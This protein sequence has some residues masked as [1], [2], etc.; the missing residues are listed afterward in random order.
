MT[1]MSVVSGWAPVSTMLTK[2]AAV[3]WPGIVLLTVLVP[4][5]LSRPDS[6]FIHSFILVFIQ[7]FVYAFARWLAGL[8]VQSFVQYCMHS[9]I[10]P[11]L[12]K[13]SCPTLPF[14]NL[15]IYSL[16]FSFGSA[17]DVFS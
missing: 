10:H 5:M 8:S 11:C 17:T 13:H 2:T 16:T 4:A 1:I 15:F 14:F 12:L 6:A 7:P 9:F 3:L